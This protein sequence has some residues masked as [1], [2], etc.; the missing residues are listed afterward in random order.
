MTRTPRSARLVDVAQDVQIGRRTRPEPA[1]ELALLV[2]LYVGYS[3]ARLAADADHGLAMANARDLLHVEAG[4][5]IEVER[6]A[7]SVLTGIPWLA[8]V[9]SYWYSLLHY[10]VTPAVLLW[11]YHQHSHRYRQ[12]RNALVIGST[13]GIAGFVLLPMASPRMLLDLD[14]QTLRPRRPRGRCSDRR[15]LRPHGWVVAGPADRPE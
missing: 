7:N 3:A 11:V 12:V 2:L 9:S 5:N 14:G 1:R 4:L 6:W 8:L 13:A 15:G 10:V